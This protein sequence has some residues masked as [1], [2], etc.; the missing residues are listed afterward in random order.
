MPARFWGAVGCQYFLQRITWTRQLGSVAFSCSVR[1]DLGEALL[2]FPTAG[3]WEHALSRDCPPSGV[4]RDKQCGQ[5]ALLADYSANKLF[6]ELTLCDRKMSKVNLHS[7]SSKRNLRSRL[8]AHLSDCQ[9]LMC[10]VLLVHLRQALF[11]D[12]DFLRGQ[13]SSLILC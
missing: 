12:P 8:W 6:G 11:N 13:S 3:Q 2:V 1:T 5:G 10:S 7:N 4:Q 9:T